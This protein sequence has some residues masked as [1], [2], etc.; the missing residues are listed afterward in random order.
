MARK[1]GDVIGFAKAVA[2]GAA[3]AAWVYIAYA[4]IAAFT[5]TGM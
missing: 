1:G 2:F 4:V 3:L 5:R